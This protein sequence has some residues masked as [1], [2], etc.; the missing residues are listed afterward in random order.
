MW[1]ESLHE[2]HEEVL[3][4]GPRTEAKG[5]CLVIFPGS[6]ISWA[7]FFLI[8]LVCLFLHLELLGGGGDPNLA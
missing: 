5:L 6:C 3:G 2:E 4:I 1:K 8:F 7:L